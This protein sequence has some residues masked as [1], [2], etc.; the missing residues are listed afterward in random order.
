MQVRHGDVVEDPADVVA[1]R[2]VLERDADHEPED[3]GGERDRAHRQLGEV[4]DRP[5]VRL[6]AAEPPV[7][8]DDPDERRD[9]VADEQDEVDEVAGEITAV[10]EVQREQVAEHSD[11][12]RRVHPL[13]PKTRRLQ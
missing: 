12:G 11:R 10:L 1:D 8:E 9:P 2:R 4:D 3:Q 7:G 5:G 13:D 6:A